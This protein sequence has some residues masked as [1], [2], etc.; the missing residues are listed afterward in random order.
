VIYCKPMRLFA[1]KIRSIV[2][3]MKGFTLIEA[4]VASAIGAAVLVGLYMAMGEGI[5]ISREVLN[6]GDVNR[7]LNNAILRFSDDIQS[8]SYFWAGVTTSDEGGE[9]LDTNPL[10]REVT[11]VVVRSDHTLAWIKYEL[12]TGIFSEDTYLIRL[13]D[14]EDPGNLRLTYVAQNVANMVLKY[15]DA[16]GDETDDL[17]DVAAVKMIL[18]IDTGIVSLQREIYVK[19]RNE[20]KGLMIPSY[21]F[22]SERDAQLYK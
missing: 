8:A 16:N 14:L 19:L 17:R 15:Y 1:L 4:V 22:E 10:P 11:F 20:N 7:S 13:S 6:R 2:K 18:T 12:V 9:V 3:G 5:D 21:D